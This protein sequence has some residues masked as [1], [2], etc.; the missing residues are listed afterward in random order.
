[1]TRSRDWGPSKEESHERGPRTYGAIAS[2]LRFEMSWGRVAQRELLSEQAYVETRERLV[3][4]LGGK[5]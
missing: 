3:H 4:E 5:C 1:M 2:T